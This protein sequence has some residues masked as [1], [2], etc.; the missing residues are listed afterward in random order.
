M[1][2]VK[3][4]EV[5]EVNPRL[6]KGTI[7]PDD[8]V[9]FVPMSAVS[10]QNREII[11]PEVRIYSEVSKG[12][13]HFQK[14]DII[15]AKITPCFE[16][17]KMAVASDLPYS[18]AF[19]STEFHVFRS[20]QN[21]FNRYLFHL[22]QS[23]QVR[24]AGISHMQGSA[25][26][27]RVPAGFF[28]DLQIPLPPLEQQKRIAD[29]L[30]AADALRVKRRQVLEQLDELVQSVFLE[31]FGDPVTNPKGWEVV[32][33][34]AIG[35]VQG[36][37]QVTP[38]RRSLPIKHPYL[39]V[40]NVFRGYLDLSE[41]KKI[42]MT[43]AEEHRTMLENQDILIVE[44]HGNKEEIGRC[45]CWDNSIRPCV[46]QNHLIRLRCHREKMN[47]VFVEHYINSPGG[48]RELTGTSRTTSG[49]NTISV[50]KVKAA[51]IKH[52]PLEL[53][54]RFAEIVS[55]IEAQKVRVREHLTELDALFASLQQQ[56]FSGEL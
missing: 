55:A 34:D 39:R 37:L 1:K 12:Y 35:S 50:S 2:T 48:R 16:N 53:Q 27:K 8:S 49:L 24:L 15:V 6:K 26:H 47:P 52:P 54:N 43:E 9:S 42:G 44:G 32:K 11:S 5:V 25:G 30:D 7:K 31:M 36:G 17:G 51:S 19:G 29:I 3:V 4:S 33:V 18:K 23:P 22:L 56:A 13:T 41:V 46:H 10:E 14:D 28:K 21:V 40:A 45:S 38:K 20:S